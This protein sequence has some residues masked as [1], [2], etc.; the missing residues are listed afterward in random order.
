MA[1]K[2]KKSKKKGLTLDLSKVETGVKTIPEGIYTVEITEVEQK[3]SQSGNDYLAFTFEVTE[4]KHKGA[5]LF[6]NCSLQAQAL[7]GLKSLLEAIGY[8]IPGK[9]F[10]LDIDELIG[11]SCEVEVAHETFEGKKKSRIVEFINE[12]SDDEEDEDEDDDD[13]DEDDDED[14]EDDEDEDDEDEPDYESMSL[15]ELKAE[16]KER[17]LKVKKGMDKDDIIE[18]LEEDDEE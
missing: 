6:H 12:D 2:T 18:M 13:D 16:A 8:E 1:K 10:D 5:K 4:G 9:A 14:E 11:E 15:K 17:G 7:F 3:E